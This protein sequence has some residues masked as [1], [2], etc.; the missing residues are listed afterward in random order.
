MSGLHMEIGGRAFELLPQW[1]QDF[2]KQEAENIPVYCDYPDLHLAAQWDAPEQLPYYEKY[3]MMPNG[4]CIP[5]GPV[6]CE[7]ICAAHG[8]IAD[9]SKIEYSLQYYCGKIIELLRQ[10]D[11]VESARFAGVLGHLLQDSGTPVHSMNNITLNQLFPYENGIYYTWHKLGDHWPFKPELTNGE[12][13][14]LGRNCDELVFSTLEDIFVKVENSM[15]VIVPFVTAIRNQDTA[16]ADRISQQYNSAAV[17]LTARV[18]HTLFCI[19]FERFDEKEVQQFSVRPLTESKMIYSFSKQF[20]RQQFID[21][22]IPFYPTLYPDTDSCRAR[23]SVNPYPHEPVFNY[24]FDGEGHLIPLELNINGKKEKAD[25]GIAAGAFCIAS[26]RVPGNIFDEL[27]LYVGIHPESKSDKESVCAI[28]CYEAAVP[29]L[30][31]GKITAKGDALH[32]KVKLPAAC[33]TISLIS[34]AWDEKL[35]VVWFEPRLK[36]RSV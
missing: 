29:L 23:L 26:F 10:K 6:D 24:A 12:V 31:S 35:S 36:Y 4:I 21:A 32:F 13:E 20:D 7:W 8:G 18:W 2:W 3:C 15:G 9:P 14:L 28:W 11:V 25:Y 16:A 27:E 22:G 5:H 1:E 30:A 19:A 34:A 17:M 33:R